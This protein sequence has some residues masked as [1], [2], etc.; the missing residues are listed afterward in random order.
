MKKRLVYLLSCLV[1]ITGLGACSDDSDENA[2]PLSVSVV[3]GDKQDIAL[4]NTL[5]L[6]AKVENGG[7]ARYEWLLDGEKV[8]TGLK[9]TFAPAK[10]GTYE[11][12][13]TVYTDKEE[14][15]A[16][17]MVNV[18]MAYSAVKSMDDILFWTGEGE[19]RSALA[20]QWISGDEWESPVKDNVH[21]LSWGYRWKASDQPT[22]HQMILAIAKAD[23]RFFVLVGPGFSSDSQSIRGFGYDANG[24]G[25]F[26]IK[27]VTTSVTY[28]ASD[29]VDGVIALTGDDSGDGYVSADPA[30][31]W[32][33]GWYEGYCSY[34]LGADGQNVP[35]SFDYSPYMA[36]LRQLTQNSWDA[37]TYSSI[38]SAGQNT[39]PFAGWMVSAVA[40]PN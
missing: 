39:Y 23:P 26:S 13:F 24:D 21:L 7:N 32:V 18:Y 27:H 38:N 20:V 1:L 14:A 11:I 19:C 35:E 31:Y 28:D 33:G 5:A 9:Y 37:W 16:S 36:G 25:H 12:K 40:N 2:L 6:E 8:S 15:S 34:F 3:N 29:F 4:G 10:A 22:G 30:D 17:V